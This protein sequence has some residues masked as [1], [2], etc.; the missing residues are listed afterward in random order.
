MDYTTAPRSLIYRERR[1]LEEFGI[2]E[3]N[4]LIRPLSD[5]IFEFDFIRAPNAEDR[6]LWCLNN[7]FYICT[8]FFLER[9]PKWRYDQYIK[10]ATPVRNGYPIEVKYVTLSLV[11]I[12]L[13]RLEDQIPFL[14]YK[15]KVRNGIL[16]SMQKDADSKYI[17][18][19]L[20]ER[21]KSDAFKQIR[22]PNSTFAPRVINAETIHD[23]L[24]DEIF[25]WVKFT[26]YW[27]E[28][29]LRDIVNAFGN[30]EEEKHNVVDILRQTSRGFYS[31]G[32]NDYP[33]QVE[34]RL[35]DIDI[36]V[37]NQNRPE[38]A[39]ID[40]PIVLKDDSRLV[41]VPQ[42]V[43]GDQLQARIHELELLNAELEKD[44]KE[45]REQLANK[46]QANS[47]EY[48]KM[49]SRNELLESLYKV[50][51]ERLKRYESILGTE[52]QLSNE[53][54]F[55]ITERIIFC[56]SLLGCSLS[57]DDISQMRMA[58][59]IARFS[60]DKC[61]AIRTTINKMNGKRNALVK[62]ANK[63]NQEKDA[64]A[65][66]AVWRKEGEKYQGITNAALNVYN[67]LHTAV[68]G[69]TRGAKV[70]NC[71]QAM[72]NIDQAYYLTERK[73]IDRTYRQ[74]D[75]DFELP[76]DEI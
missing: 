72:E 50:A 13:S 60:G 64:G 51:E 5:A 62:V 59:L 45:L 28:R 20:R 7:A 4:C 66:A 25:N 63:A 38:A 47:N 53:K 65:R 48:E 31:C 68:K 6:A 23:V 41:T 9:D 76:P 35:N 67:Y 2:Y 58:K 69:E 40:E 17:F 11:G 37:S 54:Q 42:T 10:I 73:L 61:E 52:D 70:H 75:G 21:I 32:C 56:S 16:M 18:E 30:T 43:E 49:K 19:H 71:Q 27:E 22:I 33:E 44:N 36:E 14:S 46:V 12:L 57:E 74:P 8:M 26:N 39:L 1:S 15:G 3:E 34:K 29:S 24:K 55:N